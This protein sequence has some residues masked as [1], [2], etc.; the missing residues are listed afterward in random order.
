MKILVINAGSSSLKYQ[1]IDMATEKAIAKGGCER[2]GLDGSFCKHKANGKET[3]IN[4]AMPT[5]KEAIKVVL[6]ALVDKEHGAIKSM[7]EIDAVGHRIV[8]SGEVFNDSVLLTDDVMKTIESLSELAP[9]H[10]PANIIGVK[11]CQAIMPDVPMVG[12]FDTA[13]HHT[14]PEKAYIYGIPYEAYTDYKIR[15]Y[16]F[17]GTSHRFVSAEAA[18]YLGRENDPNF[19]VITMH[20]GNGSSISAVKGGKSMDTSMSFTPLGGVPMGTRSGDLDPAIVE[21]LANKYNMTLA[22]TMTYLNKK[23]GVMGLS[24]VSSDFRDL[25]AAASGGNH[26]AALALEVFEYSCKKYL[27]A[28]T[29]ALGGVDCVVFTAGIGE[30][31]HLI[32]EHIC[33]DMEYMGLKLDERKNENIGDGISD[34]T[35][36]GSKVKILVIPTN[37]ELVI[38][39][40]TERLA[41]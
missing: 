41:K 29:A 25:T 13:F 17:H 39:R 30:H 27:G 33:K 22:Q 6:D 14:M 35:A 36:E 7:K 4:A 26:R 34:V 21:F 24:G 19:K 2:I 23:S 10:Q 20:L 18:K 31:D 40:D 37:E 32:R 11:A 15:R 12:V 28:Y 8:H 1:L 5:H 3:V 9:L 38:A 16:G